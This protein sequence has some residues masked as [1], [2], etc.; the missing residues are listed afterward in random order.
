M[1]TRIHTLSLPML[2]GSGV[3]SRLC[4]LLLCSAYLQGGFDK[5]RDCPG[6]VAE[7]THV[8]LAPPGPPGLPGLPKIAGEIG[9]SRLATG[10][11]KR[12]WGALYLG[13][14]TLVATLLADR[15]RDVAGPGRIMLENGFFGLPGLAGAFLLV[16]WI[17]YHEQARAQ[18]RA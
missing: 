15:F 2:G 9:A 10:G 4:L 5:A 3:A 14:F 7:L 17:D 1:T 13:R 16:A 18:R 12:W 8:G 11:V 6:A